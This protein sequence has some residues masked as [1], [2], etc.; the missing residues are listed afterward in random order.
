MLRHPTTD[1]ALLSYIDMADKQ[2]R[3]YTISHHSDGIV[4]LTA[5]GMT[6]M[7]KTE[8]TLNSFALQ[9]AEA[10]SNRRTGIFHLQDLP[11]GRLAIIMHKTNH[12]IIC[13]DYEQAAQFAE[14]LYEDT[15]PNQ[16]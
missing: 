5:A 7:F 6:D 4:S 10:V 14:S 15:K 13:K 9:L 2:K 8:K 11:D 12:S 3:P 16:Q 1:H